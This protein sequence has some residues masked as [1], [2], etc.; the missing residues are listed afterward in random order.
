MQEVERG[1]KSATRVV[2][3]DDRSRSRDGLRA[4]L[5]TQPGI[6]IVGVARDGREALELVETVRPDA[7]VMDA[8]MPTMDGLAATRA[9]K[10]L[11]PEVRV[12]VL[13]MYAS[14]QAAAFASGAD[15]FVIKG[16]LPDE[17]LEAIQGI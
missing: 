9:I 3:A 5:G 4:L 10:E 1:V 15:G 6:E 13:T 14:L 12:I 8:R 7:V 2:I 16:C 17:L 11:W